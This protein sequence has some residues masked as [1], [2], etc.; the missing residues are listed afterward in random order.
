M[1][2]MITVY[3]TEGLSKVLV[4]FLDAQRWW[5]WNSELVIDDVDLVLP[6]N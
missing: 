5:R 3:V 6:C 4:I 2:A 1:A